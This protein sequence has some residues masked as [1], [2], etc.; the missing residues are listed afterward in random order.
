MVGLEQVRRGAMK[1]VT[2]ELVPLMSTGKGILLEALAPSVI[3]ANLKK[4][5]AKDW[6]AGTNLVEGNTVNA[7]EIYKLIKVTAAPKWPV[8]LFGFKFTES[9]LDKL[10]SYIK[11]A[12]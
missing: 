12:S 8:E 5:I 7:E 9:D 1:Y 3:D 11:E 6:L 4:Y 10:Y 2:M